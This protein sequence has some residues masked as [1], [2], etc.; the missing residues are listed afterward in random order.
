M[1]SSI[2]QPAHEKPPPPKQ[3][4]DL[5]RLGF[6]GGASHFLSVYFLFSIH[7]CCP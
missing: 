6:N 7:G 3:N 5:G 4:N 2:I 1:H